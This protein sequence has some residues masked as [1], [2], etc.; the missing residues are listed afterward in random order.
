MDYPR[1]VGEFQQ[2]FRTDGDCLDYLEWLR[3]PGGF[4]CPS[5]GYAGGWQ[6]GDGR[7]ECAGCHRRTSVTAGTIFDR[8]RTPLTVWFTACWLFATAK[9]GISALSLQR[10]LEIGSYQTAWAMLGRL[11]SVL[12]RPGRDRLAGRVEVDETYIG[13]EEPGLRGGRARGKKVLTGIAVEVK[14]PKGIGRCRMALLADASSASLHPFVTG[15]VEPGATVI[16]DA[17]MGYH[18]LAGL[19]YVH[20]RRSQR[21]ARARGDDPGKLLPAVHRVASLAKRWL[22]STHQ[23]SVEEAHLQSYLDEFVF[24]FNRRRS[25]SR[26]L[27]FYR[28]LEL[29]AGHDPVRYRDI[30][31]GKRPRKIPTTPP[32]GRGHPPS[33]ERPPAERPWRAADLDYSG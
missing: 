26:G 21:A 19:G 5:C 23:G 3:W 20:Q 2:W 22:L 31:A 10:S 11:R 28:L 25:R 6:L 18:G 17:W 33:L 29:A 4:T 16:T 30:A 15:C 12:V 32:V 9:D 1:S 14:E 7:Y 27:V 13:G 24:R 8:T